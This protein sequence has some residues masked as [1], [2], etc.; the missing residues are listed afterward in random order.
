MLLLA[1]ALPFDK[2]LEA[3]K[4]A[5]KKYDEFPCDET[6]K[7]IEMWSMMIMSKAAVDN[8]KGGVDAILEQSDRMQKGYDMLSPKDH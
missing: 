2:T 8:T 1:D 7:G 6:K 3:L 4:D 5:I